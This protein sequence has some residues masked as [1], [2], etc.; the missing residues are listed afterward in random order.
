MNIRKIRRSLFMEYAKT[1]RRIRNPRKYKSLGFLFHYLDDTSASLN[2]KAQQLVDK[3]ISQVGVVSSLYMPRDSAM[4]VTTQEEADKVMNKGAAVLIA[5]KDYPEYPCL[6]SNQPYFV[7]AK[8]CRYYRDLQTRACVTAITGSIGKTTTK[9]MVNAVYSTYYKTFCSV[10]SNNNT[11]SVSYISQHIPA[12]AQMYV[13][14]VSESVVC[15][16]DTLSY[17][18]RPDLAILTTIDKSHFE[19]F[20]SEE[21][22]AEQICLITKH[23]P[24]TGKVIVNIDEFSHFD[25]L[26]GRSIITVS[27]HDPKA[28]FYAE[29]IQIDHQGLLF[30]VVAKDT[31]ASHSVRLHD[32]FAV[33][34]VVNALY[35]FAAG[36][37]QNIP[38]EYIVKGLASYKTIG[39]RQNVFHTD[40][41]VLVYADCY[42]A[43]ARS[44]KSAIE[45]CDIIPVKGKRIAVLGDIE[46]T[47]PLSASTHRDVIKYADQ[48]KFDILL[49]FGSKMQDAVSKSDVRKSLQVEKYSDLD[50]LSERL[51]GLVHD[52]DLV[53]FKGSNANH[54]ENCIESLWPKEYAERCQPLKDGEISF[55]RKILFW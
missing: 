4:L 16:T 31:Q 53:L 18:L 10:S 50:V 28:D 44:M 11:A 32:I 49:A 27:S 40:D 52:G 45:A 55:L 6:I 46:E 13:Q 23:M 33:H 48:S 35:A 29:N 41:G 34:N 38:V 21:K 17:I 8:L 37:C 1:V 20:G 24:Q 43:V 14:E 22:I 2:A 12:S 39:V 3:T 51:R 47:G 5:E 36:M 19:H 42:N 30:N 26:S 54:L 15:G 25:M 7:L 9:D